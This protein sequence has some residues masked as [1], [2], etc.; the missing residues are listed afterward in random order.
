MAQLCKICNDDNEL[1]INEELLKQKSMT[2]I[3][4]TFNVPYHSVVYHRDT[5]LPRK[6]QKAIKDRETRELLESKGLVQYLYKVVTRLDRIAKKCEAD[7]KYGDA[8]RGNEGLIKTMDFAVRTA[9]VLHESRMHD[10]VRRVLNIIHYPEGDFE[11]LSDIDMDNFLRLME[12]VRVEGAENQTTQDLRDFKYLFEK[13]GV[14]PNKVQEPEPEY[15]PP[16]AKMV[17]TTAPPKP[18][19]V[20]EEETKVEE[21]VEPEPEEP[22]EPDPSPRKWR[23]RVPPSLIHFESGQAFAA[24]LYRRKRK[25]S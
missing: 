5:C 4:K 23:H 16:P 11:R 24:H 21:T 10:E 22:V 13:A 17:R 1:E 6:L 2:K 14:V 18:A 25:R 20:I 3:S 12:A 8:I 19:P 15:E 9:A 7:G